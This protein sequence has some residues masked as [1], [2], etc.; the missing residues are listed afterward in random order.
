MFHGANPKRGRQPNPEIVDKAIR[1][2]QTGDKH[3]VQVLYTQ[4]AT[5]I[6]AYA[7]SVLRNRQEAEDVL[8]D[9]FVQAWEHAESYK[10][11]GKP[12]AWL[13]TITRN[14]CYS[15][16]REQTRFTEM[17]EMLTDDSTQRDWEMGIL[18]ET[19]LKD[20]SDEERQ[21]VVMHA[22]S[23]LKHREIADL[24]RI[25]LGTVLSKYRRAIKKLRTRLEQDGKNA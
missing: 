4:C 18:L 9:C 23:G 17:P 19:C 13:L 5:S 24:L 16:L 20:L 15:R 25:P 12:M 1:N 14:L 22:V 3:A 2:M 10:S 6:F 7:L 11:Q 21:I 8:H